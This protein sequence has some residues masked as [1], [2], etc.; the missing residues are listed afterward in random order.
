MEEL[1][2]K[3]RNALKI[4]AER[5]RLRIDAVLAEHDFFIKNIAD[6]LEVNLVAFYLPFLMLCRRLKRKLLTN[7]LPSESEGQHQVN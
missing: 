5:Q 2:T 1:Q 3:R 6:E 7:L 4:A